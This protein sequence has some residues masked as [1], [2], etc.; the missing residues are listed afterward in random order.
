MAECDRMRKCQCENK[1][2]IL[3]LDRRKIK[4]MKDNHCSQKIQTG[5]RDI[6]EAFISYKKDAL[7]VIFCH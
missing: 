4:S 6:S 5:G 3:R 1:K 7:R 2:S